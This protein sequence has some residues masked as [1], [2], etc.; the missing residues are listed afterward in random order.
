MCNS[1]RANCN[2]SIF[3][4]CTESKFCAHQIKNMCTCAQSVNLCGFNGSFLDWILWECRSSF[5]IF[6]KSIF[7][8]CRKA[9][10]WTFALTLAWVQ[11]TKHLT[12]IFSILSSPWIFFNNTFMIL[13]LWFSNTTNTLINTGAP[14]YANHF[15]HHVYHHRVITIMTTDNLNY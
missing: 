13:C 2:W 3:N 8:I 7:L 4:F 10:I 6:V 15:C 1:L 5:K 9:S 12:Q 11:L 14:S